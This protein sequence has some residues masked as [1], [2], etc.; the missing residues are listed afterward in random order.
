VVGTV[1]SIRPEAGRA[2]IVAG[3]GRVFFARVGADSPLARARPGDF[4]EF[5]PSRDRQGSRALAV[6]LREPA[7]GRLV[8]RLLT[9]DV[10]TGQGELGTRDG[11]KYA[12]H[13]G[14]VLGDWPSI[15]DTFTFL[16]DLTDPRHPRARRARVTS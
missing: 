9:W 3:D 1:R 8:G 10:R 15:D 16:A 11:G 7:A 6:R 5:Q 14:D 4:V 2:W 13:V 12:L